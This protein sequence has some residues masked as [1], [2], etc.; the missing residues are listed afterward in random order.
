MAKRI[1]KTCEGCGIEFS[2]CITHR[3]QPHHS[4]AC[5]QNHRQPTVAERFW[6]KVQKTETCWLWTAWRNPMG[7]GTFRDPSMRRSVLAHRFSFE[8]HTGQAPGDL[9]VCHRCDNPRCVN[10]EH[11][12]IG[13]AKDN[14][15]D[16]LAKGRHRIG[17]RARG[18]KHPMAKLSASDVADIRSRLQAGSRRSD[19]AR[20]YSIGMSQMSRIARG[21]CW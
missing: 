17:D 8:L 14:T 18:E 12:F 7:Y 4:R 10:P 21:V 9:M 13:T 1:V 11:L 15:A 3:N 20:M 16:M 2:V 19:L 5:A 6:A